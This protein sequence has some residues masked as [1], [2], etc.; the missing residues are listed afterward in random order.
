MYA[1]VPEDPSYAFFL[2]L[3]THTEVDKV[4]VFYQELHTTDPTI[5]ANVTA[6]TYNYLGL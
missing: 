4:V 6:V 1:T 3:H 5:F 2:N